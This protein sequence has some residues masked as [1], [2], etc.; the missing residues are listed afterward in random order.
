MVKLY[1]RGMVQIKKEKIM[2]RRT[3]LKII[4]LTWVPAFLSSN[5]VLYGK[6]S[7]KEWKQAL[8]GYISSIYSRD[9]LNTD[10]F[11]KYG[12]QLNKLMTDYVVDKINI[13]QMKNSQF[14]Y[15]ASKAFSFDWPLEQVSVD[16]IKSSLDVVVAL[17]KSHKCVWFGGCFTDPCLIKSKRIG[18]YG[19]GEGK[20]RSV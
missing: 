5:T 4:G 9:L 1:D 14:K 10:D 20:K 19:W 18:Y 7:N 11:V 13:G 15:Y 17:M 3:S 12:N 6:D 8:H 16:D 2:D